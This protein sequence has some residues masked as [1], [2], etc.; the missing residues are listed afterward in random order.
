MECVADLMPPEDVQ[1]VMDRIIFNELCKGQ[2]T[3]ASKTYY[4]D[5]ISQMHRSGA[6]GVVLGCTEIPLLINQRD[7][8]HVPMFDTAGFHVAAAVDFS[9]GS[10]SV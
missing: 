6:Q 10:R 9:L 5:V 8:F 4:L 2:F 7:L 3:Q 1:D